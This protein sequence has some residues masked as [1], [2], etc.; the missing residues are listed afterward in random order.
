MC[1][2]YCNSIVRGM[3][4]IR[5]MKYRTIAFSEKDD[6]YP[7]PVTPQ[8]NGYSKVLGKKVLLNAR[9]IQSRSHCLTPTLSIF[10]NIYFLFNETLLKAIIKHFSFV[11]SS[12]IS[13]SAV[14]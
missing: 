6:Y 5:S 14:C 10:L 1:K 9:A 7:S 2:F 8:F 4:N 11:L 13:I 3:M 12:L